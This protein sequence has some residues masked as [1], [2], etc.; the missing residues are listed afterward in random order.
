MLSE[1]YLTRLLSTKVVS[2]RFFVNSQ[3]FEKYGYINIALCFVPISTCFSCVHFAIA[4]IHIILSQGTLQQYVD[5]M[6]DCIFP[7]LKKNE[8][9]PLPIKFL[10]DFLDDQAKELNITDPEVLHTW[11]NNRLRS[12]CNG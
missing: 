7:T 4:Y 12:Y 1:I 5:D 10:F 11:K 2:A 3:L 8:Q 9:A 6:F